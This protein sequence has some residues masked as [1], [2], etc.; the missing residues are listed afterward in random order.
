MLVLHFVTTMFP[1]FPG[2]LEQ[3]TLRLARSLK[4]AGCHVIVHVR[5]GGT[6]FDF[7]AAAGD[8]E[9][10]RLAEQ[11]SPWIEPLIDSG[12]TEQQLRPERWRLE[13]LSLRNLIRQAIQRF[14]DCRHVII[15]NFITLVGFLATNVADDLGLPH[16]ACVVGTDF[17]RG[18]RDPLERSII[19][20]VV[21]SAARIVTMNG[22]QERALRKRYGVNEVQTIHMSVDGQVFDL[23]WFPRE[24][25][26]VALICDGGYSYKK[27]TQ[28]LI[29]AFA[30]LRE[31]G[32]PVTLALC[33]TTERGQETYWH[34]QRQR[35]W[36]R[37]P[38]AVFLHDHLEL[39]QVWQLMLQTNLYCSA[40]L[41]EGCSLAR[42]A[43]LCVGMPIVTT[44]TAEILDLAADAPHIRL[45]PPGDAE[46]FRQALRQAI[47]DI[48][49]RRLTVDAGR[50]PEWREHFSANRERH[51]WLQLLGKVAG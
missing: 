26:S 17:S 32:V 11:W 40:T 2:G 28:V 14:P 33:G 29:A 7:A 19:T 5:A 4:A 50:L 1:P 6:E 44:A 45:A 48:R 22:E 46:G 13:F 20:E 10:C 15:S 18:F 42:A 31:E 12:W 37:F 25:P 43:A 8:L 24:C 23:R 39:P 34:K 27:G 47:Q 51:E 9:I 30:K 16:I 36:E 49:D 21:R 41:G 35:L 3:W 38:D